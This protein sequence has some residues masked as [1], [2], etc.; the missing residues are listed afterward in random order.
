MR[1]IV[2]Y[3]NL[4]SGYKTSLTEQPNSTNI[5]RY[6]SSICLIPLFPFIAAVRSEV[7]HSENTHWIENCYDLINRLGC[8]FVKRLSGVH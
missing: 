2:K 3:P 6:Y 7:K 4:S 5:R 8:G 1:I